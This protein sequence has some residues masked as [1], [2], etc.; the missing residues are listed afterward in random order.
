LVN[1]SRLPLP[2]VSEK[3][4]PRILAGTEKDR[5]GV[6]QRFLRQRRHVKAAERDRHAFAAVVSGDAVS[7]VRDVM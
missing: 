6:R 2:E 3:L 4:R 7:A 1:P 5:V